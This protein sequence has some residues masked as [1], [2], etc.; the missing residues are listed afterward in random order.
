MKVQLQKSSGDGILRFL[1]ALFL[2]VLLTPPAHAACPASDPPTVTITLD[3]TKPQE[4]TSKSAAEI[5]EIF[6]RGTHLPHAAEPGKNGKRIGLTESNYK[7]IFR[8]R[9]VRAYN[10]ERSKGCLIVKSVDYAIRYRP[11]I[12]IASDI[13]D[14]PCRYNTT[15]RHEYKHVQIFLDTAGDYMPKIKKDI[16][17][18]FADPAAL[19]PMP[20]AA[21]ASKNQDVMEQ[22]KAYLEPTLKDFHA[23]DIAAQEKLDT[24]E[25][26]RHEDALCHK[27]GKDSVLTEYNR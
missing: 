27:D 24:R 1:P 5:N 20:A 12:Y 10:K 4:D 23:A 6:K 16:Q 17:D 9:A 26:Y 11:K 13:R 2:L 25:N 21:L 15:V 14:R 7:S 8:L 3:S 18:F 22:L 19:G